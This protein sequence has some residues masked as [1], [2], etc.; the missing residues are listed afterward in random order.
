MGK[1][2][3]QFIVTLGLLASL[4]AGCSSGSNSSNEEIKQLKQEIAALKEENEKLK[5]GNV[6]ADEEQKASENEAPAEE[7]EQTPETASSLAVEVN[8]AVTIADF[9]EFTVTGTKFAKIVKPSKPGTFYTYYEAKEADTTYLAITIKLKSLLEGGKKADRFADVTVKYN[10]KYEY[11]TFSTIE[12]QGGADFTYTNITSIEPL[13]TA[14]LL[15]LA[16]VPTEVE[17]GTSPLKAVITM[18]DK[19]YE[20]II[21]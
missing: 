4:L 10:D 18:N 19:E 15:Y 2:T 16:E 3:L 17:T 5:Q 7:P 21:R 9:A 12:D 1:K 13:K 14:T 6:P 11:K 20:L 8:K